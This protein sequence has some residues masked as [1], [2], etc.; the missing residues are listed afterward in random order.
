MPTEADPVVQNWYLHLDKGQRF[1]VV[2]VDQDEGTVEIQNFDGNIEEITI[3][4]WYELDIEPAAEPHTAKQDRFVFVN[5][6]IARHFEIH[7]FYPV[8]FLRSHRTYWSDRTNRS[9]FGC[10]LS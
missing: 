1:V 4:N 5:K 9:R 7:R 3:D 6:L 8:D 10:S 2:A